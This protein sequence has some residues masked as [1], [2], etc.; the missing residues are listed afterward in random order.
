MHSSIS[1]SAV[2][3]AS[4]SLSAYTS[5]ALALPFFG[6]PKIAAALDATEV[7]GQFGSVNPSRMSL[8][9]ACLPKIWLPLRETP[10]QAV[11]AKTVTKQS[12]ICATW[13][14]SNRPLTE[15]RICLDAF[16]A[17]RFSYGAGCHPGSMVGRAGERIDGIRLLADQP[18]ARLD[19]NST[20]SRPASRRR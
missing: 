18:P 4:S 13:T 15:L 17:V 10:L 11:H 20:P 19:G 16:T 6:F 5:V 14:H 3:M 7:S 8:A 12:L 9:A 2:T 1:I